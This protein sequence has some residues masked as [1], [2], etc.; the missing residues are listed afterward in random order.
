[1]SDCEEEGPY[2]IAQ[3][4]THILRET[5]CLGYGHG[6][7]QIPANEDLLIY[8]YLSTSIEKL[9]NRIILLLGCKNIALGWAQF[10]PDSEEPFRLPYTVLALAA[11]IVSIFLQ[12]Y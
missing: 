6:P 5:G 1:M 7:S 8:L 9:A 2:T 11:A 3:E 4:A 10:Y 12:L